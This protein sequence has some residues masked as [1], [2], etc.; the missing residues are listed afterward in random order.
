MLSDSNLLRLAGWA[1]FALGA[2]LPATALAAPSTLF[3]ADAPFAMRLEAPFQAVLRRREDPEYQP[4]HIVAAGGQDAVTIDLRVRVRGKSRV[5]ACEFP[6]LLLNFSKDQPQ[7]SPFAGENRLKLV[8][9]CDASSS[10]DQYNALE[11]QVYRALNLLTDA[12]LRIRPVTVTY[13]DSG[14][15]RELATKAGF[16]IEDEERFAERSKLTI[17]SDERVDESRYDAAALALVDTFQYFVGNTDWSSA[18]GPAGSPCCHNVVPFARADGVLV[19]VPYDFD[20]SGL[21]NAPYALPNEKLPIASVRQRLYRGRCR[22]MSGF[23]AAF[24]RFTEMRAAIDALFTP[25]AGLSEKAA[26]GARDYIAA[27][28]DTI[29]D[30]RKAERAFRV[31]CPR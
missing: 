3:T 22:E 29:G 19:P 7:G 13:F 14:R 27:F 17:V 20:A 15:G 25:S 10:F 12:S 6:P 5:K 31:A 21:V 1:P 2:L 9:H 11:R 23:D 16:L 28:Y 18:A 4:A 26:K 8:T 30:P 24:A